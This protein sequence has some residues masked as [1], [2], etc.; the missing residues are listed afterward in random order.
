[1]IRVVVP[2]HLRS[3]TNDRPDYAIGIRLESTPIIFVTAY[4]ALYKKEQLLEA[5][6][7]TGGNRTQVI[8]LASTRN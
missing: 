4:T 2:T 7:R 1:M 3:Y 6:R 5:L 8:S